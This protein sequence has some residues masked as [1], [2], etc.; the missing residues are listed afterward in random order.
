M[1]F[2]ELF[3]VDRDSSK[4]AAQVE[5]YLT[6]FEAAV[7]W[8]VQK[9]RCEEEEEEE[10]KEDDKEGVVIN[11]SHCRTQPYRDGT[12]K[13]IEGHVGLI[14]KEYCGELLTV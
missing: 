5:Y 3:C 11:P 2:A 6:S 9:S 1:R 14:E 10:E 8:I 12:R 4:D 13:L 7:H